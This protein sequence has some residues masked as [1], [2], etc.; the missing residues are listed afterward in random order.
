MLKR[1]GNE[2][3]ARSDGVEQRERDQESSPS[4]TYSPYGLSSNA[5]A[6]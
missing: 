3:H 6:P 4:S 1:A 2:A 5:C